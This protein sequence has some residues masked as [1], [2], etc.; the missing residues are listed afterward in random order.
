[1]TGT[2]EEAVHPLRASTLIAAHRAYSYL[3]D[4]RHTHEHLAGVLPLLAELDPQAWHGQPADRAE[5]S[6]GLSRQRRVISW[7]LRQPFFAAGQLQVHGCLGSCQLA[8]S[9][10]VAPPYWTNDHIR[11]AA[12][13]VLAQL[14][15]RLDDEHRRSVQP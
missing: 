3:I 10:D 15:D 7:Q 4:F 13:G 14:C 6:F 8:L 5:W 12:R 11:T 2:L 9:I 1:M